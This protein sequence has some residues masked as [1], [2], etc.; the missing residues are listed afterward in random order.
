MA[1]IRFP[2]T[3]LYHLSVSSHAVVAAHIE[4]LGLTT[5]IYNHALGLWGGKK[6]DLI[7]RNLVSFQSSSLELQS[8]LL[9]KEVLLV[10]PAFFHEIHRF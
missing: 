2:V 7:Y 1:H 9:Y 10:R 8:D 3:E 6:N 4:E 5:R